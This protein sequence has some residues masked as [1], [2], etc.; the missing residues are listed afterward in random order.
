MLIYQGGPAPAAMWEV[1]AIGPGACLANS[2]G[3]GARRVPSRATQFGITQVSTSIRGYPA[4]GVN[5]EPAD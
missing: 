5:P 2:G 4:R 3:I 1:G